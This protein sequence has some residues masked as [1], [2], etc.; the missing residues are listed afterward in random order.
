MD[1]LRFREKEKRFYE[2]IGVRKL[3]ELLLKF[4][5]SKIF[6]PREGNNWVLKRGNGIQDLKDQKK[7]LYLNGIS[8][9]MSFVILL[10]FSISIS[11][12]VI[13]EIIQFYLAM[14]QRYNYIRIEEAID[15]HQDHEKEKIKNLKIH[16]LEKDAQLKPH[17]VKL[18]QHCLGIKVSTNESLDDILN[19]ASY[20][21]LVYYKKL[22][23]QL[24]E[25]DFQGCH[26]Y[27]VPSPSIFQ[28]N[29]TLSLVYFDSKKV[30]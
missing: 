19:R 1:Y 6:E 16:I 15:K 21:E 24:E 8:H 25:A 23:N 10:P 22:F 14:I 4:P 2:K 5:M 12:L 26:Y 30:K 9:A 29:K 27:E 20:F 7:W 11:P 28:S 17:R 3:K 13:I 18:Y